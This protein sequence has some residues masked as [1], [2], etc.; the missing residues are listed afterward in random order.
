M[1]GLTRLGKESARDE[2]YGS[3]A[4]RGK[5]DIESSEGSVKGSLAVNPSKHFS[6]G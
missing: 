6:R 5:R 4:V 1:V 3:Y 2:R